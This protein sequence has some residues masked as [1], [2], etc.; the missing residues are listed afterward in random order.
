MTTA[1]FVAVCGLVYYGVTSF[2]SSPKQTVPTQVDS[3]KEVKP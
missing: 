3:T 1:I 2:K